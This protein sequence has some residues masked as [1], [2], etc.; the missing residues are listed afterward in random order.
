MNAEKIAFN[1]QAR[2]E[3]FFE[4]NV[5]N[6]WIMEVPASYYLRKSQRIF[7]DRFIPCLDIANVQ[8]NPEYRHRGYFTAILLAAETVSCQRGYRVYIENLFPQ[9]FDM[10]GF[11]LRR[12]YVKF[13][14]TE[15]PCFYYS[16]TPV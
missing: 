9:P 3:Q 4:S 6:V 2:I 16:G 14:F 15:F 12:G 1:P 5:R 11:L 7:N 13:T 10:E 8:V